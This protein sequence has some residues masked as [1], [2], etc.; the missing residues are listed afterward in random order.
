MNNEEKIINLLEQILAE[1][2]MQNAVNVPYVITDEDFLK[3]PFTI[4]CDNVVNVLDKTS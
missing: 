1:L 2:K 4:T 3:P